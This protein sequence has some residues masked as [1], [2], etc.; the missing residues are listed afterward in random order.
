M[1]AWTDALRRCVG[2]SVVPGA[3]VMAPGMASNGTHRGLEPVEFACFALADESAPLACIGGGDI[4]PRAV[5]REERREG[6]GLD[7][8]PA[9]LAHWFKVGMLVVARRMDRDW[10]VAANADGRVFRVAK[11]GGG[12]CPADD[13]LSE[14]AQA[15]NGARLLPL[16]ASV[17]SAPVNAAKRASG[18]E[19]GVPA[20]D[21]FVRDDKVSDDHMDLGIKR[22]NPLG[23]PCREKARSVLEATL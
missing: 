22:L 17:V 20:I 15:R 21:A 4:P 7:V 14:R 9:R 19:D 3:P 6:A 13:A 8:A 18:Q 5:L 11:S 10:S 16:D 2:T 12:P 23:M 1:P